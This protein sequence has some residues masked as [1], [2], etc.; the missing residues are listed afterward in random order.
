MSTKAVEITGLSVAD[1]KAIPFPTQQ[2]MLVCLSGIDGVGKTRVA[3]RLE[4]AFR[5]Q[6][7]QVQYQWLC[8]GSSTFSEIVVRLVRRLLRTGKKVSLSYPSDARKG[9]KFNA[10]KA[11]WYLLVAIDLAH[12][13]I[14]KVR[15][16][17]LLGKVVIC[18]RYTF[19][20][21]S[22]IASQYEQNPSSP[23]MNSFEKFFHFIY[24]K[25]DLHYL[26]LAEPVELERLSS[27]VHSK[28]DEDFSVKNQL[29]LGRYQACANFL[30]K[31]ME[32]DFDRLEHEIVRETIKRYWQ[33]GQETDNNKHR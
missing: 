4:Y 17:L 15:L 27:R 30:V 3:H 21:F 6:G 23:E 11:C 28:A 1:S 13:C 32:G 7:I 2:A 12:F 25:P 14:F 26:L 10:R 20:T 31:K 5:Q 19:D 33:M 8:G 24:P 16:P 9:L 22:D 29:Y 18:D